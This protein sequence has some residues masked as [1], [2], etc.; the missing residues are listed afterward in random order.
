MNVELFLHG[1]PDGQDHWGT[2]NDPYIDKFYSSSQNIGAPILC[3]EIIPYNNQ[4]YAYYTYFIRGLNDCN[5]RSGSYFGITLRCDAYCSDIIGVYRVLDVAYNRHMVGHI[6]QADN[7]KMA[8]VNA[9]FK[10]VENH[11]VAVRDVIYKFIEMA[12]APKAF[13]ALNKTN[14][15]QKT[16]RWINPIDIIRGELSKDDL[17][18]YSTLNVS[19]AAPTV[20]EIILSNQID[21]KSQKEKET[22]SKLEKSILNV[23]NANSL[24]TRE[25]EN[26]IV[27]IKQ[28]ESQNSELQKQCNAHND[29]K[30]IVTQINEPITKLAEILSRDNSSTDDKK[31]V[32]KAQLSLKTIFKKYRFLVLMFLLFLFLLLG[33][34]GNTIHKKESSNTIALL[35]EE[36]VNLSSTNERLNKNLSI[37]ENAKLSS[38]RIK[39]LDNNLYLGKEYTLDIDADRGQWECAPIEAGILKGN[40]FIPRQKG[41]VQISYVI[42]DCCIANVKLNIKK[43]K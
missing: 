10:S 28:L 17:K 19:V 33:V 36:I 27:L 1:V 5:G 43:E 31:V 41:N 40:K 20:Q 6:V 8:Y 18:E 23:E 42:D 32:T 39:E 30:S 21:N 2:T 3:V 7:G 16:Q 35:K 29:L 25:L 12:I 37:L 22:I 14:I 9:N 13:M 24:L 34:C 26:K 11:I 4:L 38:I 15:I